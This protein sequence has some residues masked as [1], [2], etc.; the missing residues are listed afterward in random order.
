MVLYEFLARQYLENGAVA[1]HIKNRRPIVIHD[2]GHAR[3]HA[4]EI[5][6]E[7][8]PNN[9]DQV[10]LQLANSP[11]DE[12]L[13]LLIHELGGAITNQFGSMNIRLAI[14]VKDSSRVNT[15]AKAVRSL[16]GRGRA[17]SNRNWRWVCPITSDALADLAGHLRAYRRT[18][19]ER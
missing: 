17:Y 7:S 13:D 8:I 18:G 6:L 1:K 5:W 19:G 15:L 2:L 4:C 14:G 10:S 9:N 16:I 11:T 12:D 3:Q